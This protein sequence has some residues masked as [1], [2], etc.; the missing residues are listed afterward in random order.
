MISKSYYLGV[1]EMPFT[2]IFS[3]NSGYWKTERRCQRLDRLAQRRSNDGFSPLFL[4]LQ[5]QTFHFNLSQTGECSDSGS[6]APPCGFLEERLS[7]PGVIT[8][9]EDLLPGSHNTDPGRDN[10]AHGH[11]PAG[12]RSCPGAV[13]CNPGNMPGPL[14]ACDRGAAGAEA[15]V[16]TAAFGHAWTV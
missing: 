6:Q 13:P 10:R 9:K 15:E 16:L 7:S 1:L 2:N 4:S 11:F 12:G 8:L 3:A 5:L 14:G